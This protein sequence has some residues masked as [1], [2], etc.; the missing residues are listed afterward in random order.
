V[1]FSGPRHFVLLGRLDRLVKIEEKRVSLPEIEA[2][3]AALDVVSQCRTA[4]VAGKHG[5]LI[6]GAVIVLS[7]AGRQQLL[8]QGKAQLAAQLK[9][10]VAAALDPVAVPRRIRFVSELPC[11]SQGKIL[12]ADIA[13]I[14]ASNLPEP[15][16]LAAKFRENSAE[17]S[18]VFLP[19][20]VY[21]DGH[22]PALKILP[23][24][25]QIYFV[26]YFARRLLK[27][28]PLSF[29]YLK[30]LKFTGLIRPDIQVNL[31]LT[32]SAGSIKF[33]YFNAEKIFSSGEIE[34]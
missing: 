34:L 15:V 22:F 12:A 17:F 33:R 30:K 6:I 7:P 1:Q 18:L 3:L 10:A 23:A 9:A 32:V 2:R 28:A 4:A 8:A 13:R 26:Q 29:K 20:A 19:A 25:I 31:A 11:N 14:L 5:R 21:F 24:V 16:V 27:T